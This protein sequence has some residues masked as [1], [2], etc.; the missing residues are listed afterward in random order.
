MG[1]S[2]KDK[3]AQSLGR[4]ARGQCPI[5]AMVSGSSVAVLVN[6]AHL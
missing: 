2:G 5:V 4:K 1:D 6:I 3:A